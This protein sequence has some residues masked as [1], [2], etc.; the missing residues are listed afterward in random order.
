MIDRRERSKKQ[1]EVKPEE[2][3]SKKL[4]SFLE[5]S[6]MQSKVLPS[7]KLWDHAYEN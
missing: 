2:N 1:S 3:I 7:H 4:R 5:I 6:P